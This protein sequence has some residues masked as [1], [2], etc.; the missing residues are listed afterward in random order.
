MYQRCFNKLVSLY[1]YI[2]QRKE[3]N[4]LMVSNLETW[5]FVQTLG[6][7]MKPCIRYTLMCNLVPYY[8]NC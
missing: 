4:R 7:G 3:A 1:A 5:A 6:K 2:L 8:V